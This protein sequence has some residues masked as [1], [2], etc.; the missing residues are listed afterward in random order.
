MKYEEEVIKLL[1]VWEKIGIDDALYLLSGYFSANS[2]YQKRSM[3][4]EF[5]AVKKIREYAIKIIKNAS[6]K[7]IRKIIVLFKFYQ[8]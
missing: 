1:D 7:N 4:K 3:N 8:N 5:H 2:F 6:D